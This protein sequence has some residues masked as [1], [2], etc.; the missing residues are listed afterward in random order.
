MLGVLATAVPAQ[1]TFVGQNG[2]IAYLSSGSSCLQMVN[3]DG[4]G[5]VQ[6]GAC[7]IT[8]SAALSPGGDRLLTSAYNIDYDVNDLM[9]SKL[10][11]TNPIRSVGRHYTIPT[12]AGRTTAS[13]SPVSTTTYVQAAR[14]GTSTPR[15]PT[16]AETSRALAW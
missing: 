10:D 6:P 12:S 4:T 5:H 13:G 14:V 8:E 11:G 9:H 2:K 15:R 1:A 7:G 3:P 16:V